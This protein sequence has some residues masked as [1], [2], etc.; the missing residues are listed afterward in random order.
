MFNSKELTK[1]SF[2]LLFITYRQY[3]SDR[4]LFLKANIDIID[5]VN[6]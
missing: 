6:K 3:F 5:M 2:L 4:L 1:N